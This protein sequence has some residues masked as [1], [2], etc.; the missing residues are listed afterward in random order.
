MEPILAWG[1]KTSHGHYAPCK[2]QKIPYIFICFIVVLITNIINVYIPH[3]KFELL[4]VF[5]H[6]IFMFMSP[7]HT[8]Q[9]INSSINQSINQV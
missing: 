3:L 9:S 8:D 6:M 1:Q 5:D 7:I 4:K 2:D